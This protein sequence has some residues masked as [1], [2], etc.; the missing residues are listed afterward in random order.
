VGHPFTGSES[1]RPPVG[2][3]STE[4]RADTPPPCLTHDPGPD[5]RPPLA[6]D[7]D[8]PA[9]RLWRKETR[10]RLIEQRCLISSG[11]RAAWSAGITERLNRLL[12]SH[13]KPLIGFYWPFRGEY[14][15]RAILAGLRD[16]GVR[17]ALP[18]VVAKAEPLQFRAWWP[19]VAMTRGVW[20]IP[21]PAVGDPVSPDILL[22]PLVGFDS[23]HY[24][25]GYGGGFYDRTVA[26]LPI[27]PLCIGVGFALSRLASI[28]PQA[29]DV[30]MDVVITETDG[31]EHP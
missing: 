13:A 12:S 24:R 28:R 14:D 19:G 30:P 2:P 18:V 11:D 31:P 3:E 5:H 21:I 1:N 17:L 15:A 20:D 27:K 10:A 8:W 26:A 29:H 4:A 9:V 23:G 22:A 25:L 16:R 6:A 7:P